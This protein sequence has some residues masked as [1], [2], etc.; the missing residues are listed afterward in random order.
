MLGFR[1]SG[2]HLYRPHCGHCNACIPARVPVQRF[3]PNRSQKR[4]W[5]ANQ[6]LLV[7]PVADI[8]DQAS[9]QLY[10]RY[11]AS[12]HRDG[13]MYPPAREQY[14]SFLSDEWGVTRFY[15]MNLEGK[16]IAVAVV[17]TLEDGLSAGLFLDVSLA[18]KTDVLDIDI[19]AQVCL[20]DLTASG[21]RQACVQE[22]VLPQL[23]L[24]YLH[25]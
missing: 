12:R 11:I 13:D 4:A 16:T 22:R 3:K 19:G 20:Q 18:T 21:L 7:E 23:A 24:Q 2:S 17:D 8:N 25:P 6:D 1:R 15:N 9:Y 10:R 14:E 5:K